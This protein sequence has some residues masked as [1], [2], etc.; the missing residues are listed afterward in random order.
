MLTIKLNSLSFGRD[1]KLRGPVLTKGMSD[2]VVK[3]FCY[4]QL[5][6]SFVMQGQHQDGRPSEVLTKQLTP[7]PFGRDAKQGVLCS[8]I[9]VS[10]RLG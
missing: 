10:E 5:K 1:F 9:G 4:V 3:L 7:L 8:Q 2:R 6:L